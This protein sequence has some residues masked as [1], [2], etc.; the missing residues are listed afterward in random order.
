MHHPRGDEGNSVTPQT[1]I[2]AESSAIGIV[3]ENTRDKKM[4]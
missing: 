3:D 1:A 2:L 4:W